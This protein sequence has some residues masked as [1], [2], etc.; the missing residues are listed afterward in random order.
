M[1]PSVGSLLVVDPLKVTSI[2]PPLT[3][4]DTG[5][6]KS[7][8]RNPISTISKHEWF[9]VFSSRFIRSTCQQIPRGDRLRPHRN[10]LVC[11]SSGSTRYH[12]DRESNR[13][14]RRDHTQFQPKGLWSSRSAGLTHSLAVCFHEIV[15]EYERDDAVVFENS[16]DRWIPGTDPFLR[17]CTDRDWLRVCHLL[18]ISTEPAIRVRLPD[19]FR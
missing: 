10:H 3:K 9:F 1:L 6:V 15:C 13:G 16:L 14:L 5:V 19:V 11:T 8:P 2:H 12:R 7:R 4:C 17:S 18:M